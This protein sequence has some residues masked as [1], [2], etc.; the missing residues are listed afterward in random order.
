MKKR[1][2]PITRLVARYI[3]GESTTR[4]AGIYG[5]STWTVC[6][7][8]A[9]AGVKLRKC[10]APLGSA[11][12]KGHSAGKGRRPGGSLFVGSSGYLHSRSRKG[13]SEAIHRACWESYYRLPEGFHVHHIDG[14][15]FNNNISN[16]AALAPGIHRQVH[17]SKFGPWR[18]RST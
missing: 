1:D 18:Y 13:K 3:M 10:G 7:R 17:Y 5:S 4:L 2:L 14:D 12:G 15:R 8:L 9:E 6:Q 16:L 11:Y